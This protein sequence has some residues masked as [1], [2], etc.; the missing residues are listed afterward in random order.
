M[1]VSFVL[2][3][4]FCKSLTHKIWKPLFLHNLSKLVVSTVNL[5][6]IQD[7]QS[8]YFILKIILEI[9]SDND[10]KKNDL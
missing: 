10:I 7:L 9:F 2:M 6:K 8:N 3:L 1:T 4:V 5:N